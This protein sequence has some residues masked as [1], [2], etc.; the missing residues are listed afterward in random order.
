MRFLARVRELPLV[1]RIAD[2][3][4]GRRL[5]RGAFWSGM[6][7]I[8]ARGSTVVASFCIARVCGKTE[9]GEYGMVINTASVLSAVCGM[10]MGTTVVKYVAQLRENDPERAGRILAM[11]MLLT[12]GTAVVFVAVF[13]VLSNVIAEKVLAAPQLGG[14]L[15]LAA[16]GVLFGILN[17]VQLSSL[18]G[19]E[20]YEERAKISVIT[21]IFS[22]VLLIVASWLFGLNGAI[23]VF[24]ISAVIAT[25]LT[26]WF[27]VPVWRRYGLRY[28]FRSMT[29]EWRVVIGFSLPTFLLLLLGF[30][31]TWFT[32]T[33]LAQIPNGYEHLAIINA[34]SPWGSLIMFIVTTMSAALVPVVSNLVGSDER[35]RALRLTWRMFWCN[36]TI[37]IPFSLLICLC[38]PV[39]LRAYGSGF[40]TGVWAFCLIVLSSGIS[41]VYQPMY[42]YLVGA[43][44]MWTNF[45]VV[46]FTAFLQIIIA[47][48][49]VSYG[50]VGLAGAG[51]ILSVARMMIL[52]GLFMCYTLG[53]RT[54]IFQK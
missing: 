5:L 40:E 51:M 11:A 18:T 6:G 42:N 21:G 20:A 8:V 24:S 19:C 4:L 14:L 47:W 52:A 54:N 16:L 3:P 46:V 44:L 30:P 9:F 43:G 29:K 41:A 36:A 12:W 48:H 23:V 37:V 10:G 7:T 22:A 1:R 35:K 45:L 49:M 33:L 50:S 28:R 27:M 26:T 13:I 15:R 53:R 34:A 25:L 38:A 39:I 17:E 2:S 31:V 32:R